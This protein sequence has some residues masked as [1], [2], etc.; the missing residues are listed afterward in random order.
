MARLLRGGRL[1]VSGRDRGEHLAAF[2]VRHQHDAA[3]AVLVEEALAMRRNPVEIPVAQCICQRQHLQR[4]G[5]PLHLGIEHEANA[6][7]GFEHPLGRVLPVLLVIVVD[8]A[9][10]ENDQ[11][12]RGSR[13]QKGETHWQ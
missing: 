1:A 12:Q 10:R 2:A 3:F 11:R 13:D 6:A 8:D 4:A 5:H 9:G 7:H